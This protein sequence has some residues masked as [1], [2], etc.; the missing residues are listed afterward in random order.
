MTWESFLYWDERQE[1]ARADASIKWL[2]DRLA[3]AVADRDHGMAAWLVEK[4]MATKWR[5]QKLINRGSARKRLH[6]LRGGRPPRP[7]RK[8]A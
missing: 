6:E 2:M 7:Y 1:V 8:A 3:R 4:V 5:R